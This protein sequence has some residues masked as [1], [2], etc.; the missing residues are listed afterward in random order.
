MKVRNADSSAIP[1][2]NGATHFRRIPPVDWVC[3]GSNDGAE[4]SA[5]VIPAIGELKGFGSA[6]CG[7]MHSYH[8]VLPNCDNSAAL[9]TA[10]AV[11]PQQNAHFAAWLRVR[12]ALTAAP[13]DLN[14]EVPDL[15]AQGVT[16]E[17]KQ[18]GRTDLIAAGGGELLTR[19]LPERWVSWVLFVK[20]LKTLALP[21]GIEPVFQP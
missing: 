16:V 15:L 3:D 20:L 12:R 2:A 19:S 14:V 6:C 17:P 1:T 10:K 11:N 18:V 4:V 21:T 5:V 13:I 9:P 7:L 8:S